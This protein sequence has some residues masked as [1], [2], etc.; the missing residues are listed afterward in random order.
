MASVKT[1]AVP[2]LPLGLRKMGYTELFCN[3]HVGVFVQTSRH[4][5]RFM[6]RTVLR[7]R[8]RAA[9]RLLSC[10]RCLAR[11]FLTAML[12]LYL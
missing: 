6:L 12:C 5:F 8:F 9:F 4:L 1:T 11:T 3:I 2:H 10:F 7:E